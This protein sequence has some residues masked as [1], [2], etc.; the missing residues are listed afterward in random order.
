MPPSQ[1]LNF[2]FDPLECE[3]GKSQVVGFEET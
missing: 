1:A 2:L 3:N